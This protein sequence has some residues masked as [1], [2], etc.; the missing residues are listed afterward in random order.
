MPCGPAPDSKVADHHF[1]NKHYFDNYK[2]MVFFQ[3][4][5]KDSLKIRNFFFPPKEKWCVFE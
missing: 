1:L 3:P 2:R 5:R 4:F